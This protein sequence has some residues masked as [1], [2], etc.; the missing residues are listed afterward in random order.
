MTIVGEKCGECGRINAPGSVRCVFC[1]AHP[2]NGDRFRRADGT[3]SATEAALGTYRTPS[4][5]GEPLS[6]EPRSPIGEALGAG[7][8]LARTRSE[9]HAW[10]SP[11]LDRWVDFQTYWWNGAW[12]VPRRPGE[13]VDDGG[14]AYPA[15]VRRLPV[16]P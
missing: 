14:K 1:S 7:M 10:W 16:R 9:T 8:A 12:Y 6:E 2:P 3:A 4:P 5:M 13:Y 15:G 11:E